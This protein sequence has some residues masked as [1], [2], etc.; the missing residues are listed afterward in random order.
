MIVDLVNSV[1]NDG[2]GHVAHEESRHFPVRPPFSQLILHVLHL[3]LQASL[4]SLTSFE[5]WRGQC[6]SML[7]PSCPDLGGYKV[8]QSLYLISEALRS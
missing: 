4:L 7:S 2:C 6:T 3:V 1:Q 5:S 8:V